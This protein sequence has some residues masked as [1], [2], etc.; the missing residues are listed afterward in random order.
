MREAKD[1]RGLIYYW[2]WAQRLKRLPAVRETRVWSLGWEDPLE[3]EMVTHSTILAW[4]IPWTEKPGRLQSMG[5]QRVGHDWATSSPSSSPSF[6]TE[7]LCYLSPPTIIL[8]MT[9]KQVHF[10]LN[11]YYMLPTGL[12]NLHLL[13]PVLTTDSLIAYMRWSQ[14]WTRRQQLRLIPLHQACFPS[15]N[16]KTHC[17]TPTPVFLA[18]FWFY[19]LPGAFL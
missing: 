5:S 17:S 12:A 2:V 9:E 7:G 15:A 1:L 8:I 10:S 19:T 16:C 11:S 6:I 4:R 14:D 13:F 18:H 3:K